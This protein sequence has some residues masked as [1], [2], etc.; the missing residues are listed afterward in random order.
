MCAEPGLMKLQLAAVTGHRL[1]QLFTAPRLVTVEM[2]VL[3]IC[4]FVRSSLSW[5]RKCTLIDQP[6]GFHICKT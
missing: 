4:G 1:H 2:L 6:S 5:R 3:F